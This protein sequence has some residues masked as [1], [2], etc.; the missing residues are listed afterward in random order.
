MAGLEPLERTFRRLLEPG[1]NPQERRLSYAV[2]P[3]ERDALTFARDEA[4]VMEDLVVSVRL[5]KA[6]GL[7]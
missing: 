5:A 7:E 3:D 4:D 2:P 1:E 6:I